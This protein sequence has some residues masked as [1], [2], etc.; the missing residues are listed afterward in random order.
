MLEYLFNKV[1]GL[2]TCKFIKKRLQHRCFRVKF[3]K[4]LRTTIL[5]N[6]FK[7]LPLSL[8]PVF[9]QCQK[10]VKKREAEGL[11]ENIRRDLNLEEEVFDFRFDSRQLI[12]TTFKNFVIRY[13]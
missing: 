7:Q 12:S 1:A 11:T 4:F 8:I 5:K 3:S 10:I 2:S 13:T 6:I 9:S